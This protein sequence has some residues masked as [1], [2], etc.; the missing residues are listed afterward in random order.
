MIDLFR[1]PEDYELFIYTLTEQFPIVRYSTV[2]FVRRGASLARV[3]G[4]IHFDFEIRLVIRER[5]VIAPTP[6]VIDAYGY[7]GWRGEERLF[8]Y[9]PQPH[10]GDLL[11][12]TTYPHHKHVPPDIKQ[13]RIP[14]EKMSFAQPNLPALIQEISNLINSITNEITPIVD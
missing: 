4:D 2:T 8:W 13:N 11:L 9:D 7:E 10:P 12:Q 1:A 3:A 5:I 14:A 6:V